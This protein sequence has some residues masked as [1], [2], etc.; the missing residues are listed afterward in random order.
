MVLP[1][2]AAVVAVLA[3]RAVAQSSTPDDSLQPLVSYNFVVDQSITV[4]NTMAT[5]CQSTY[6]NSFPAGTLGNVAIVQEKGI[7]QCW[8]GN[9]YSSDNYPLE[10]GTLVG[11][12]GSSFIAYRVS[13]PLSPFTRMP[14]APNVLY[15]K[16]SQDGPV[17]VFNWDG[18]NF[19]FQYWMNSYTANYS[20]V[21][22]LSLLSQTK[23]FVIYPRSVRVSSWPLLSPK[24]EGAV[25][26]TGSS[27][28]FRVTQ[29]N[30]MVGGQP[31]DPQVHQSV[32]CGTWESDKNYFPVQRADG[33][34]GVVYQPLPCQK[35]PS[36]KKERNTSAVFMAWFSLDLTSVVTTPLVATGDRLAGAVSDGNSQLVVFMSNTTTPTNQSATVP[37]TVMKFDSNTGALMLSVALPTDSNNL[38]HYAYGGYGAS[39]AWSTRTGALLKLQL[40]SCKVPLR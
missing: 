28:F 21:A 32:G 38:D 25:T 26:S 22:D 36:R 24:V 17:N 7:R 5:M 19:Q 40:G 37:V 14:L 34:E 31:F 18:T 23:I 27:P 16:G 3:A 4:S 29:R 11:S 15:F 13:P 6:P 39:M 35:W 1:L 2:I 8:P 30:F 20:I 12:D 9:Q 33:S 10:N